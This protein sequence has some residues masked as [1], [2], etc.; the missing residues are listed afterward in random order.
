MSGV[1]ERLD[2]PR[3]S[4]I[5]AL[6]EKLDQLARALGTQD[7]GKAEPPGAKPE[8]DDAG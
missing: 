5:D 7:E 8:P 3:R 2:L 6:N 1:L 4:D